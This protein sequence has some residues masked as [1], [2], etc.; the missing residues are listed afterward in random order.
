MRP[1]RITCT[2][3]LTEN[4]P[5]H[6]TSPLRTKCYACGQPACKGCSHLASGYLKGSKVRLCNDCLEDMRDR[7]AS[8]AIRVLAPSPSSPGHP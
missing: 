4:D 8:G 3:S 2:V 1:D 5:D 6:L 7:V